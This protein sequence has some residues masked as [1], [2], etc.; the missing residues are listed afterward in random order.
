MQTELRTALDQQKIHF[1]TKYHPEPNSGC[2]IWTGWLASN[3]YGYHMILSKWFLAHRLS[4]ELHNGP[5]P[6]GLELDHLCRDTDA[7]LASV[8][9]AWLS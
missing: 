4:Y 1:L 3:G 7:R 2:W 5:I 6:N 8:L 9:L